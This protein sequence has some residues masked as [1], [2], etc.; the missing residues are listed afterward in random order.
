MHFL[1]GFYIKLNSIYNITMMLLLTWWLWATS[2]WYNS[3]GPMPHVSY[4]GILLQDTQPV[5]LLW[6][7]WLLQT[8]PARHWDLTSIVQATLLRHQEKTIIFDPPLIQ[9]WE[10][11]RKG[12]WKPVRT[13]RPKW[14][15]RVSDTIQSLLWPSPPG[16]SSLCTDYH[17][18]YMYVI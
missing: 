10:A 15:V 9:E 2:C 8:V 13:R 4:L 7:G 17:V 16:P 12:G 11:E 1:F 18:E 14:W 3:I 6:M 5:N